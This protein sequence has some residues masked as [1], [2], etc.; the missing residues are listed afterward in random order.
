[1]YIDVD[2]FLV[3]KAHDGAFTIIFGYLLNRQIEVLISRRGQ[4]V[5]GCFFVGFC[6]HIKMPV[7]T[8]LARIRQAE[9][10]ALSTEGKKKAA[11]FHVRGPTWP[12]LTL[13]NNEPAR[14]G[15][16]RPG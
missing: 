10:Q 5:S 14:F 6:R 15:V 3:T 12:I 9:K 1:N 4:F 2:N 7:S 16:L 13:R 11:N 8:T